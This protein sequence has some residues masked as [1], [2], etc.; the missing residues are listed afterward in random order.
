MNNSDF[1]NIFQGGEKN[2]ITAELLVSEKQN[3]IGE[4]VAEMYCIT[5]TNG[6]KLAYHKLLYT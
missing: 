6:I 3:L 1:R 4:V 5:R 2:M